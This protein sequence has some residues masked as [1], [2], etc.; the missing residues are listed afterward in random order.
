[1]AVICKTGA[2]N[3]KKTRACR[4]FHALKSGLG[5]SPCIAARPSVSRMNVSRSG[6]GA[7]GNCSGSLAF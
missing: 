3:A 2:A 1:M 4:G 6:F 7:G 5:F